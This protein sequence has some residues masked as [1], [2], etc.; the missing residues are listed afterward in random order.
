VSI[1]TV[2]ALVGVLALLALSGT[3]TDTAD[4][5]RM[6]HVLMG[7]PGGALVIWGIILGSAGYV[8]WRLLEAI[9]DPYDFG[10]GWKG[11][12]QRIAIALS[13]V[14]YGLL[15]FSAARIAR[16]TPGDA[17]QS[18]QEQQLLVAQV[19]DWPG[20]AWWVG[21]TGLV[22]MAVGL[23]QFGLLA[24]RAYVTE[25]TMDRL[26]PRMRRLIHVLA[27]YG[28]AARSV[29]LGVLGYFFVRAALTL[30]PAEVGDTDTAFDF[31][32]G[33]VV[34]DTAFFIVALGTFAYGGFMYLCARYYRFAGKPSQET[35]G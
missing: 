25:L 2:Y 15:A 16:G 10:N 34:G 19:L 21:G 8:V 9:T 1:G 6:V 31:I 17:E 35:F 20:G 30:N 5:D 24:R 4:E 14:G 13:A 32:G 29:I 23:L 7:L 28:Y 11:L 12:L 26:S 22:L 3:H 18:E 27:W 33:G